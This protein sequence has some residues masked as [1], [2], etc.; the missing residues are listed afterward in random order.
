MSEYQRE[1]QRM[2]YGIQLFF[3][4]LHPFIP[5]LEPSTF[6]NCPVEDLES[7]AA[8]EPTPDNTPFAVQV[9]FLLAI[10]ARFVGAYTSVGKVEEWMAG[11]WE[12]RCEKGKSMLAW[13]ERVCMVCGE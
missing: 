3:V 2:S 11:Q 10:S 4:S 12:W 8:V 13:R 7:L 9:R 1:C 5:L 6:L